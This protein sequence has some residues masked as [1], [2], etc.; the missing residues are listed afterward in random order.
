[1]FMSEA[2][3]EAQ[4][5]ISTEH[6]LKNLFQSAQYQQWLLSNHQ[7][8]ALADSGAPRQLSDSDG[9]DGAD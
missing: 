1:M 4:G 5:K 9:E 3:Y 6:E 2:E 7:R 8:L